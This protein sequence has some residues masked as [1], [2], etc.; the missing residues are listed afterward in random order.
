M[1]FRVERD[2]LGEKKVPA[3]AYYGVQ[4][5]RALENFKIS[6]IKPHSELIDA[7][8]LIKKSA[9]E[10]HRELK[11]IPENKARAITKAIDEIL[12]G[13]FRE[14]FVVDVYQ[15]GAGTSFNMNVNE[16]IANRAIELMGGKKGNYTMVHPND[17]VNKSQST[18]DTFP[19]AMRIAVLSSLRKFV[20]VL[21]D[22]EDALYKKSREFR[23]VVK[24]GRTHLK[25]AVPI[26]LGQE[27]GGYAEIIRECGKEIEKSSKSL[28]FLGI[29]GSA[30]GTGVNV[31]EG[32]VKG[33]IKKLRE[34]TGLNFKRHPDPFAVMQS[35]RDFVAISSELRNLAIELTKISNDLRLMSSGPATGINEIDLPAVQPGSSIMPG[36]VN[37]VMA[38]VMN[39]VCFQVIGNDTTIAFSAQAGQLELNVM[40]PVIIHNL[41][42]SLDIMR[43]CIEL[44]TKKCVLGIKANVEVC[45]NYMERTY[46]LATLLNPIIGYEKSAEIVKESIRTGRSIKDI[47]ISK[48]IIKSGEWDRLIAR[49]IRRP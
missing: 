35:M 7:M 17:D 38:E 30:V 45:R 13:K 2:F 10:T 1:K 9:V 22:L 25:D 42:F 31:P 27:F 41:L 36:K 34:Y 3:D 5:A 47:V 21:K 14:Q 26:T 11:L 12:S 20:K 15:A 8:L 29:G 16:V 33:V 18:N 32:Y 19:T 23:E 43:N 37:P 48:G 49:S 6:G 4:T 28:L 39:M 46:G 44:F 40:M 24:A